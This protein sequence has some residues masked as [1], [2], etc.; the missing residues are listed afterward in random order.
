MRLECLNP[1][2]LK[3]ERP[4]VTCARSNS[5]GA[6][7]STPTVPPHLPARAGSFFDPVPTFGWRSGAAHY[8]VEDRPDQ[9]RLLVR[10]DFVPG[11]RGIGQCEGNKDPV[12]RIGID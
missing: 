9:W 7:R 1:S 5:Y 4:P 10:A 2:I 11:Q 8:S 6:R 3:T 12:I